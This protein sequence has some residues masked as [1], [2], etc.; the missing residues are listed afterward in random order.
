MKLTGNSN[1]GLHGTIYLPKADFEFEGNGAGDILNA[2]VICWTFDVGGNGSV[3][4]TYNPDDA[5]QLAGIG[6]VQVAAE[7]LITA[8]AWAG[9][10][11]TIAPAP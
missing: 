11:D 1:M 6:L 2:Q 7:R 8:A 5:I 4:I 3:D 9:V 10:P